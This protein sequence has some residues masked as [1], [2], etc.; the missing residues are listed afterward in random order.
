MK[1][2][3]IV[4]VFLIA[5]EGLGYWAYK[6]SKKETVP[7]AGNTQQ[8]NAGNELI[9]TQNKS[10]GQ[11]NQTNQKQSDGSKQA[12]AQENEQK[13]NVL[14]N[15]EV[16]DLDDPANKEKY[17]NLLNQDIVNFPLI[18]TEVVN[19]VMERTIHIGVRKWFW[20]PKEVEANKGEKIRFVVH[21][22]SEYVHKF[23]LPEFGQNVDVPGEGAIVEFMTDKSGIFEYSCSGSGHEKMSAQLKISQ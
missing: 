23:S 14:G 1:L 17:K 3:G 12:P 15:F 22:D 7:S 13:E 4:I 9:Q 5:M 16:I 10:E 11:K 20:D 19:G 18:Q 6:A 21:N 2:I 8:E